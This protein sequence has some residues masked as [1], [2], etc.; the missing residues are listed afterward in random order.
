MGL[1]WAVGGRTND[2]INDLILYSVST[3]ACGSSGLSGIFGDNVAHVGLIGLVTGYVYE[4]IP[5]RCWPI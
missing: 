5:L 1:T 4:R 3:G 2:M